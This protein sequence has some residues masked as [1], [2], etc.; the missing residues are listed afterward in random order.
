[1]P[2]VQLAAGVENVFDKNYQDHLGGYNRVT[3]SDVEQGE[4]LPGYGR[5]LFARVLYTF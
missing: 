1:L 5:N 4:R 3:N 2:S